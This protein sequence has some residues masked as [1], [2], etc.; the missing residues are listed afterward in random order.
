VTQKTIEQIKLAICL[1]IMICAVGLCRILEDQPT[2]TDN[3]VDDDS[4]VVIVKPRPRI[5][6]P[7]YPP[8]DPVEEPPRR[9][10]KHDTG[11][12]SEVCVDDL[13]N[14][15]IDASSHYYDS[16]KRQCL[17]AMFSVN[18]KTRTTYE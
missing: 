17:T 6:P 12:F 4:L 5:E 11:I 7:R 10:H 8:Q 16:Y 1:V 2:S 15:L 3:G 18:F 9:Q 14:D 13:R